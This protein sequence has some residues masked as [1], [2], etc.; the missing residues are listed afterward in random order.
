MEFLKTAGN[1]VAPSRLRVRVMFLFYTSEQQAGQ[2]GTVLVV[3][4]QGAIEQ[5]LDV[6]AHDDSP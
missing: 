2:L 5:L 4:L 3:K 1:L 6:I